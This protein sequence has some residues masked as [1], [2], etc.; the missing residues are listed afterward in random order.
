MPILTVLLA[1]LLLPLRAMAEPAD[2]TDVRDPV[3]GLALSGGSAKGLAHV[4]VLQVLE[5]VGLVPDV[6]TGTS[7]GAII[8]GLYA[9]G[10][11]A[12]ALKEVAAS[13]DWDRVFSNVAERRHQAAEERFLVQPRALTLPL[14]GRQVGLPEGLINGQHIQ[15]A[16]AKLTHGVQGVSDFRDLQIPFAAMATDLETGAPVLLEGGNLAYALR[17]SMSIPSVFT[18]TEVDGRWLVDG[19]AARNLPVDEAYAMGA[20]IVISVGFST[21]MQPRDSLRTFV[22]V[23]EQ[24]ISFYLEPEVRRQAERADVHIE[25]D[26][27]AFGS[28]DFRKYAPLIAQGAMAAR[29]LEDSLRTLATRRRSPRSPPDLSRGPNTRFRISAVEIHGA[30]PVLQPLILERLLLGGS[31]ADIRMDAEMLASGIDRVYGT[32]LFDSA[33]YRLAP[34]DGPALADSGAGTTA[35]PEAHVLHIDVIERQGSALGFGLRYDTENRAAVLVELTSRRLR[36]AGDALT[37][38]ARFGD[39]TRLEALYATPVKF[40]S[41]FYTA[42]DVTLRE[43]PLRGAGRTRAQ[44]NA[45]RSSSVGLY[46]VRRFGHAAMAGPGIRAEAFR[47]DDALGVPV[48]SARRDEFVMLQ[49]PIWLEST[50]RDAFP[51]SGQRLQ[52]STTWTDTGLGAK[53]SFGMALLDW[54]GYLPLTEALVLRAHVGLGTTTGTPPQHYRFVA[55]GL[56]ERA[57]A[58]SRRFAFAGARPYGLQGDHLQLGGLALRTQP[59]LDLFLRVGWEVARLSDTWH[60]TPHGEAFSHA[61]HV[62]LGHGTALGPIEVALQAPTSG[63]NPR[64][65]MEVGYNF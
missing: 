42:L 45:V 16:L 3:I 30:D 53:A 18:P 41:P 46:V 19:G 2:S 63:G 25:V 4:G 56:Q 11:D 62:T 27:D 55:G 21:K 51:R 33:R 15:A 14:E 26:V 37:V 38:S 35:P 8:G 58:D 22:D 52:V 9:A 57:M 24:T 61:L 28:M 5:D 1:C 6:I 65:V 36:A 20:D 23:L 34:T 13:L 7:M 64:V 54:Q 10:Y 39:A 43:F 50:D 17:A 31:A 12:A 59:L 40:F 47:V 60:W 32:G 44:R 48:G 29:A 49:F